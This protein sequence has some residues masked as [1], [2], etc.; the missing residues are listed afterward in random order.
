ME[1]ESDTR[2]TGAR[3]V[4][5]GVKPG[6]ALAF[7]GSAAFYA[8][9]LACLLDAIRIHEFVVGEHRAALA[10]AYAVVGQREIDAVRVGFARR[11]AAGI[12][13]EIVE[14]EGAGRAQRAEALD[15][16]VRFE[17]EVDPVLRDGAAHAAGVVGRTHHV[18]QHP[19]VAVVDRARHGG[20]GQ[21]HALVARPTQ[22][23][24]AYL[25]TCASFI[26]GTSY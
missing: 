9:T 7:G 19:A 13:S 3:L 20:A 24:S 26:R 1:E 10:E 2:D 17:L 6:A 14:A 8:S 22:D 4:L 12:R 11:I 15:A 25:K 23:N 21:A 16:E 5:R 18:D